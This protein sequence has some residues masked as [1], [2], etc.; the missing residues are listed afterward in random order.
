MI[1]HVC[2]PFLKKLSF[3]MS[4]QFLSISGTLFY[5]KLSSEMSTQ[6]LSISSTQFLSVSYLSAICITF[7]QKCGVFKKNGSSVPFALGT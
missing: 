7:E 3:E 2:T 4:S 6:F 1:F 5:K